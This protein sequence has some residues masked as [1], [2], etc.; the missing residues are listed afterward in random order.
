[1]GDVK[2]ILLLGVGLGSGVLGAVTIAF[3]SVFPFALAALMRG[4]VAARSAT[5]PFGPFL[6]FGGLIMLLVPHLTI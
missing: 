6:A 3:L 2:L 1:M 4:G 5:L